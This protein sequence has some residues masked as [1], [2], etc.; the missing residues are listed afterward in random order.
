MPKLNFVRRP[1]QTHTAVT[2]K[3]AG[4]RDWLKTTCA[5]HL[6]ALEK[7]LSTRKSAAVTVGLF[8]AATY[9]TYA[10]AGIFNGQ[11]CAA[12]SN[13]MGSELET[14]VSLVA[15]AGGLVLWM[16]DDGS[17]KIKL[18]G[19]RVVAGGLTLFN[20]PVIYG[21]LTGTGSVCS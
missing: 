8:Y 1:T 14:T 3:R 15:A 7:L 6:Q 12:Y 2:S 19:L 13:I 18:W 21:T 9:S 11:L 17:N 4:L 10:N 20:L 5:D 16:L